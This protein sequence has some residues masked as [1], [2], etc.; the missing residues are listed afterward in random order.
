MLNRSCIRAKASSSCSA[1]SSCVSVMHVR[2][3]RMDLGV[4]DRGYLIVGGTGGMGLATAHVLAADGARLAI[5]GRD[6]T[7]AKQAADALE[8]A[9]AARVFP[10]VADVSAHGNADRAVDEGL[11]A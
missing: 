5:V 10:I 4:R 7:R 2:Y 8:D 6:E 9:H 11:A 3:R 1:A